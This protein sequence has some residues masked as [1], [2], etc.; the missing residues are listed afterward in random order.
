MAKN[1]LAGHVS[2]VL[3][4]AKKQQAQRGPVTGN[5]RPEGERDP[6]RLPESLTA[7]K[8]GDTPTELSCVAARKPPDKKVV[9]IRTSRKRQ[10]RFSSRSYVG[11]RPVTCS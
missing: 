6:A 8:V 10:Y 4:T 7:R 9:R 3:S 1:D 2:T 5:H 11:H